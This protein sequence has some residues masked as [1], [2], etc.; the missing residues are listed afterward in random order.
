MAAQGANAGWD[1]EQYNRFERERAQPFFDL[2]ARVPDG[3][4]REVADLGCGTGELTRTLAARWPGARI[5]GVDSSAAMLAE[6]ARREGTPNLRFV[7]A[8]LRAFEP[9][10]P[11]DR[12]ISNAALQ[13][14]P[15]HAALLERLVSL[16]APGGVLAVQMPNNRE[17]AAY[18]GLIELLGEA[19]WRGLRAALDAQPG[20]EAPAWY[21]ERLL[22]LGLSVDLWETV[23]HH[24][25]GGP[26]D[27]VEWVKGTVLRPVVAAAGAE[28][29]A[30]LAAYTARVAAA[31]PVG[32]HGTWFPF[33][34]LFFIA[35]LPA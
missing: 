34:R 27:V 33:R 26:R 3:Q 1:P 18:R 29:D 21:A 19:R 12:L 14:V 20:A 7:H 11:L 32:P 4:V 31:C 2:L 17:G 23:Y 16:L 24:R 22:D 10:Q 15:D 9:G 35:R 28:A 6:A 30:F 8:D 25:L 5:Q 13:W